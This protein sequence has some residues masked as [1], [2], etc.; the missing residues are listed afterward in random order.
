MVRRQENYPELVFG[1][2][3]AKVGYLDSSLLFTSK[4]ASQEACIAEVSCASGLP[5]ALVKIV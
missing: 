4:G 2:F 3:I 5:R 1:D